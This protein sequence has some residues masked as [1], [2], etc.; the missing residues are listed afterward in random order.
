MNL[1]K[2][3]KKS[4]LHKNAMRAA[5]GYHGIGRFIESGAFQ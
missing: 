2:K 4:L 3:L 5:A 1:K